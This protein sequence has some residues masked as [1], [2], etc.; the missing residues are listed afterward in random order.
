MSTSFLVLLGTSFLLYGATTCNEPR[1]D[2][3]CVDTFTQN[4][5]L[6]V[7]L[8]QKVCGGRWRRVSGWCFCVPWLI[9]LLDNGFED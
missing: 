4:A 8:E 5:G 7:Y 1:S 6:F 3:L 2:A 9:T